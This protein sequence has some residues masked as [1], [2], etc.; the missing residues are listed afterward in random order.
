M[1]C[2]NGSLFLLK[3]VILETLKVLFGTWDTIL[4]ILGSRGTPNGHTEAQM[5]TFIDFKVHLG[6]LLGHT[7]DTILCFS[8]SWG[9]KMGDGFQVHVFGD[10][11]MEMMPECNGCMC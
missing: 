2:G 11:G 6:S 7:L 8:V 5:S 10:P 1:D 3:T 4:V 9:S